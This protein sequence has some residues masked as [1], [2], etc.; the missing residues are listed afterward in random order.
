M[1]DQAVTIVEK[2]PGLTVV[3]VQPERIDE[4]SLAAMRAE[5]AAAGA[6]APELPVALDLAKVAFMPSLSLGGLIQLAQV[7]KARQ[8]RLVLVN[9]QAA[10]R[11]TLVVTR[12]DRLFEIHHDLSSLTG[13]AG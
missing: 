13:G 11:E 6:G 12:L 1:S 9:L 7:F 2:H 4:R 3:R 5:V 8:Q 10:V